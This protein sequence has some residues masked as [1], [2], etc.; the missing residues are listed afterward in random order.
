MHR[1]HFQFCSPPFVRTGA[2]RQIRRSGKSAARYQKKVDA[3]MEIYNIGSQFVPIIKEAVSQCG[4]PI[5]A[6][7]TAPLPQVSSKQRE[8]IRSLLKKAG[9]LS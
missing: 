3:L 7:C 2:G 1:W 6:K 9:L 8:E 5:S 4:V